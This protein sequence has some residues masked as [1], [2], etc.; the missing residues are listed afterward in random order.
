MPDDEQ[1]LNLANKGIDTLNEKYRSSKG[2]IFFLFH[3]PRLF[4]P[5]ENIWMGYER[6]TGETGGLECISARQNQGFFRKE[7]LFAELPVIRQN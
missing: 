2:D 5:E 7:S 3:R 6:K 4:N 1:L